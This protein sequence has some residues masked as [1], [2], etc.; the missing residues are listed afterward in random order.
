MLSTF[1]EYL[2]QSLK[3][4]KE[5]TSLIAINQFKAIVPFFTP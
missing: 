5:G 4:Q 1:P 3:F 2:K